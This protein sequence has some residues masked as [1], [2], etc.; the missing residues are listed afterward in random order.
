MHPK[1][2]RRKLLQ[3]MYDRYLNDPLEMVEPEE[4]A[5]HIPEVSR[6]ELVPNM[7]YLSDRRLV[8][9]MIGYNPPMFAAAR[10]TA[11][12]IDLVENRFEFNL[13]F[14]PQPGSEEEAA[15]D[16]PHLVERLVEEADF[17]A[18]DGEE[19]SSLLRDVQFLRDELSRPVH[20]WRQ[21]VIQTVLGWITDSVD[22][23]AESLP[24]A[25][26]LRTRVEEVMAEET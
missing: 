25:I 1:A 18:L 4:F 13:R 19:R 6:R 17:S 11:N 22:D 10:I 15:A 16:L 5:T 2:V 14:P 26:V 8:E 24:S 20:R 3:F 9:L 12:G 23:P 21:E 7:H